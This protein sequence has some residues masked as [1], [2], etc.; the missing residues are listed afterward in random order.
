MVQ[1]LRYAIRALLRAPGYTLVALAALALGIGATTAIFSFVDVMLLRPL[2][3][4]HAERLYVPVSINH[5]RGLDRA[6]VGFADYEDWQRETDIFDAVA[7]MQPAT[8]TVTSAAADPERASALHVSPDFFQLVAVRPLAG[9]GL[10]PA[11]HAADAPRVTVIGYALWQ[12]RFGGAPGA[13]GR[14]LRIGSVPHQIVGILAPRAIYPEETQL[15]LPLRPSLFTDEDRTRRDNLIFQSL[16]RLANGATRQQADARLQAIAAR[17]EQN[18]PASR[19]GWTNGVLPLRDYVVEPELKVALY[20]LLAAVGAVLLIACANLANLTLVRG[21]G[22][23]REMGLRLAVGASR[24]RLIRQLAAEALVLSLAGGL[25]GVGVAALS[26]HGLSAIVPPDAPF[27][28]HVTLDARVMLAT[29]G[30]T[31]FT[32]LMIGLLPALSTTGVH[33]SAAVKEGGRGTTQGRRTSRLRGALVVAE[34]AMAV[35]LLVTAGL[36]V[37]SLS[38]LTSSSTGADI[39]RVLAAAI[40]VPG[41]RYTP[42]QRT[43][44]FHTL[45]TRLASEPGVESATATSYL[46]AGGG[47]FDL[48]RV[49]LAEGQPEPPSTSDVAAMWTVITSGY[50]RTLGIPL[51]RGRPFA[52]RDRGD[53]APVT[54]VSAS[55]AAAM[56]PGQDPIGRRVRSWRDENVYREIVGVAADVAVSSLSDRERNIV[57]VPHSQQGWGAMTVALRAAS[58]PPELLTPT[59]RRVVSSMDPE[60]ALSNVGTMQVFARNSIARERLSASLLSVL[61]IL[62]LALAVLGV[63]GVM[64]YSVHLRRQEMGVR[65]ALGAAPRDLYRLVLGRGV[66]LTALGLVI[67]LAGALATSQLLKSLLYETSAFDPLAFGGMTLV[68]TLAAS[69]ACVLPARRA[70]TADPL[71]A[72][73]SE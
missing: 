23:A 59:L 25:L 62:A 33:V 15:F 68:L 32:V 2:P 70:S 51:L 50:F 4:P 35:V 37:R 61:A 8:A 55:F 13:L 26:V 21:A 64:S 60:L 40:G 47:G 14:D 44:F 42:A 9:R 12:R 43:D 57:Y 36:L 73:R 58:G 11:D 45:T 63:Y 56:F 24:G 29:A 34:V 19:K 71:L 39:D 6:S 18:N 27:I 31:L 46:P 20:V 66:G 65:L 30:V 17:V 67:G 38:R 22:R 41:A 10:V 72:L 48:G 52:D 1:D 3:Y 69:V 49:F 54:I 16:A 7:I 5:A 28:E 53:S